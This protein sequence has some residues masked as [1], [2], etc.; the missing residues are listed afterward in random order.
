MTRGGRE[1][2]A[3]AGIRSHV[4]EHMEFLTWIS[5]FDAGGGEGHDCSRRTGVRAELLHVQK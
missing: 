3:S 1:K 5:E 2:R 4:F